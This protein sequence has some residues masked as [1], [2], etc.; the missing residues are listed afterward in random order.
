M[1]LWVCVFSQKIYPLIQHNTYFHLLKKPYHYCTLSIMNSFFPYP[2]CIWRFLNNLSPQ[3]KFVQRGMAQSFDL[4]RG[5]ML[6]RHGSLCWRSGPLACIH[7]LATGSLVTES[8]GV[9]HL[10]PCLEVLVSIW[11]PHTVHSAWQNLQLSGPGHLSIYNSWWD[12]ISHISLLLLL[13][14]NLMPTCSGRCHFSSESVDVQ[15]ESGPSQSH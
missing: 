13:I 8:K 7:Q 2:G 5:I 3:M 12:W 9:Q 14:D 10:W 15:G 6:L 4:L 11:L 1:S